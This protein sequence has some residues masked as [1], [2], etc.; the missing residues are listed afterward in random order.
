MDMS[1]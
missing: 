1:Q